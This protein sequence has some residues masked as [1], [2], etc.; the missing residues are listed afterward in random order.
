MCQ[1]VVVFLD[2]S[3][4][5]DICLLVLRQ[6][7]MRRSQYCYYFSLLNMKLK[8]TDDSLTEYKDWKLKSIIIYI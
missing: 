4:I 6:S 7:K 1:C 8:P 5:S 3:L 2:V